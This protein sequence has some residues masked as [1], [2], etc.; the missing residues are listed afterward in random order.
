M[1]EKQNVQWP[2]LSLPVPAGVNAHLLWAESNPPQRPRRLAKV[3][4]WLATTPAGDAGEAVWFDV[5]G[6]VAQ[7]QALL[8][9]EVAAALVAA[10]GTLDFYTL[11]AATPEPIE[12][13]AMP[14][15]AD[16]PES[17]RAGKRAAPKG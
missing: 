15:P 12:P 3:G 5:D 9:G 16:E 10:A 8:E 2:E 17:K 11:S 4:Y 6:D 1:A 13:V 14:E 7:A